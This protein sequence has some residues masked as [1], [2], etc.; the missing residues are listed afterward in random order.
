MRTFDSFPDS[1]WV[2]SFCRRPCGVGRANWFAAE[3]ES[4]CSGNRRGWLDWL[5]LGND[6]LDRSSDD[7]DRGSLHIVVLPSPRATHL[8]FR[9]RTVAIRNSRPT[10]AA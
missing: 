8:P 9:I 4:H 5:G 7:M 6:R 3:H 10:D 2:Y 1:G